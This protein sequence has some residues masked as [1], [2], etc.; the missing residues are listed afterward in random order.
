MA[1]MGVC[2]AVPASRRRTSAVA[3]KPSISGIWQSMRTTLYEARASASR[4]ARPLLTTATSTPS[5]ASCRDAISWF[6]ELSS[7][8]RMRMPGRSGSTPR[9]D[10]ASAAGRAASRP[11]AAGTLGILAHAERGEKDDGHPGERRIGPDAPGELDAVHVGHDE[12]RDGDPVWSA[13]RVRRPEARE[14]L[15]ATRHGV[16]VEPPAL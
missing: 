14:P 1:M 12:I 10:G 4:A 16:D 6:T 11:G 15:R 5:F 7:A 3:A 8:R 9:L 13:L 2:R